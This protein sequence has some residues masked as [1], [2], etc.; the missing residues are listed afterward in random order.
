MIML[1]VI[2]ILTFYVNEEGWF[3]FYFYECKFVHICYCKVFQQLKMS[4]PGISVI[5]YI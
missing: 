4:I 3:Y 2:A 5:K 1:N